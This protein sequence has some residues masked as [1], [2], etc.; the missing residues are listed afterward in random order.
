MTR[1]AADK[2]KISGNVND[3]LRRVT[4]FFVLFQGNVIV[5]QQTTTIFQQTGTGLYSR[6]ILTGI[7]RHRW[8]TFSLQGIHIL[9]SRPWP[10]TSPWSFPTQPLNVGWTWLVCHSHSTNW[11]KLGAQ[12]HKSDERDSYKFDSFNLH[13]LKL[14]MCTERKVCQE[15]ANRQIYFCDG[16]NVCAKTCTFSV[17]LYKSKYVRRYLK[18][19]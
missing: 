15:K 1:R 8:R 4:V 2:R 6:H 3:V 17:T 18:W 19:Q 10:V 5:F 16:V 7:W 14:I 9:C 13:F 12:V 11:N